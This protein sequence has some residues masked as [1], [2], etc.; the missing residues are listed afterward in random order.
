MEP[1]TRSVALRAAC[2]A[3]A[4]GALSFV[5]RFNTLGG[6]LG[7]FGNDHFIHLSRARQI[8]AGELPFRDFNDPGAPLTSAASA[9]FQWLF[10]YTLLSDAVLTIGAL[11]VGAALTV[12]LA[13]RIS[14]RVWTGVACGL[15]LV[16]LGPRPYNY[17]K[18]LVTAWGVWACWR[19]VDRPRTARL[20]GVAVCVAVGFL[21]RHDFVVYLGALALSTVL[22]VHRRD[23]REAG[24]AAAT[25]AAAVF[26]LLAPFLIYLQLAGGIVDYFRGAVVFANADARRTS[27]SAP[28]FDLSLSA[29]LL[30]IATRP[31]QPAPRVNVQWQPSLAEET[32]AARE[33]R[34]GLIRGERREG[35]TWNYEAS[36]IS[37]NTLAALVLDPAVT[38]T[39][40]IDRAAFVL[41]V[42]QRRDGT[43]AR[44]ERIRVAPELTSE[45]NLVAWMYYTLMALPLV[46]IAA[47]VTRYRSPRDRTATAATT[48]YLW[49]L[50]V[51]AG[52][53]AAGFLTRG[54]IVARLGDVAV[55]MAILTAWLVVPARQPV[56]GSRPSRTASV[57]V[58]AIA[59]AVIACS[60]WSVAVLGAVPANLERSRLLNGVTAAAERMRAV[61][62]T[63]SSAPPA[64]AVAADANTPVIRLARYIDR[65]TAPGDRIFVFGHLPEVY[66]FSGRSFAGGH[67]WI[68]PGYY[69]SARDQSRTIE[70]L[71]AY[72]V[73]L[74][75]AEQ[76][77]IY[78]NDYRPEFPLIDRYLTDRYRESGLF[79][80]DGG[81]AMRV[82][83]SEDQRRGALD[84]ETGLPCGRGNSDR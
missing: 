75:L 65:C 19:Y 79:A 10:G 11:S 26:V 13:A 2:A 45:R 3:L 54:T 47:W 1:G 15:L 53:L 16:A 57:P 17:P 20:I 77:S 58:R 80:L 12:W 46:A 50:I 22:L 62:R 73:P 23:W 31:P 61:Y 69:T 83:A 42:P 38:D 27:F 67:V 56:A 76:R 68:L 81:V 8:V 40:G 33:Q 84:H 49:P 63:L 72:E 41:S 32:R 82:L 66:F 51:F 25:L 64:A 37:R 60:V 43:L 30:S 71:R 55:P 29:P 4:V 59:L 18:I 36:D 70:R 34:Y 9:L 5:Y 24:R 14:H 39:H 21:F 6:A 28:T 78:D 7:G 44:L 52:L 74:V 35:T 48:C